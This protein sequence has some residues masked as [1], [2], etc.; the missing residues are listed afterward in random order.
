M[1]LLGIETATQICATALIE[2]GLLLAEFR[3]NIKNIHAKK[4]PVLVQDL[5]KLTDIEASQLSG[6]AVS[7]GPGSFT[8]LRIGLSFA[9][10]LAFADNIPI[11]P[12]GTL[13]ALAK[14]CPSDKVVVP[15]LFAR[16]E[17]IYAAAFE[18]HDGSLR[19]IKEVTILHV[20]D[21]PQFAPSQFLVIPPAQKSIRHKMDQLELEY[22]SP[23]LGLPAAVTVARLGYEHILQGWPIPDPATLEP[24][25]YQNFVPGKPKAKA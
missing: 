22:A 13:E 11:I 4:L 24:A 6:I 19:K 16:N 9:K 10:G 5:C 3:L 7:I 12:V 23:E 25:Y 8:G 20:N 17:G 21:L 1:I 18:H 2:D 14:Q 15:T